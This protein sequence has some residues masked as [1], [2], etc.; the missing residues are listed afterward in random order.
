MLDKPLYHKILGA[1]LCFVLLTAPGFGL[2]QTKK[3][4][5]QA[6]KK[7]TPKKAEEPFS[8]V[9]LYKEINSRVNGI[10]DDPFDSEYKKNQEILIY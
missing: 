3:N 8:I 9:T 2:A 7:Q 1:F 6:E 4:K 5:P 10:K